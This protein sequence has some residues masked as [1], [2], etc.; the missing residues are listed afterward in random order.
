MVVCWAEHFVYLKYKSHM[1]GDSFASQLW[2]QKHST[3]IST[4]NL[5]ILY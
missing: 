4:L 3:C 2:M 5:S 1:S